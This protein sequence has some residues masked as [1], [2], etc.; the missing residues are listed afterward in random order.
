M[1]AFYQR[2]VWLTRVRVL[3]VGV[4]CD[5]FPGLGERHG[6]AAF[7]QRAVWLTRVHVLCVGVQCDLFPG[8]WERHGSVLPASNVADP[9]ALCRCAV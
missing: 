6:S 4:Q 2:V 8:L 9:C 3:F 7:Y 5:L 1:A